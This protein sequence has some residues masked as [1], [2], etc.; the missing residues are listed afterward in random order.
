M[1]SSSLRRLERAAGMGALWRGLAGGG[2]LLG[3]APGVALAQTPPPAQTYAY[4]QPTAD[5]SVSIQ[6]NTTPV[7][8]AGQPL[9]YML[10]VGNAGP[11]AASGVRVSFS[12]ANLTNLQVSGACSALPCMIATLGVGEIDRGRGHPDPG[13]RGRPEVGDDQLGIHTLAR[14]R[15]QLAAGSDGDRHIGA[16]AARL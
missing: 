9:D 15:Q 14:A 13:R 5:V 12:S 16:P 8:R 11:S 3:L 1:R 4:V 2:M 6:A 7:A 10:V